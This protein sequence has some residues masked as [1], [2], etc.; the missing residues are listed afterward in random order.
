MTH[1]ANACLGQEKVISFEIFKL[2]EYAIFA[3]YNLGS[4]VIVTP[5]GLPSCLYFMVYCINVL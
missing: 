2:L 4:H 3:L 1:K 5:P